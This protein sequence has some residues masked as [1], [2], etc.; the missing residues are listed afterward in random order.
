R[1]FLG[2]DPFV[3]MANRQLAVLRG[4]SWPWL[5]GDTGLYHSIPHHASHLGP[6]ADLDRF[7]SC[8]RSLASP[9][10]L[11]RQ[12]GRTPTDES[13]NGVVDFRDARLGSW[14]SRRSAEKL[15][16]SPMFANPSTDS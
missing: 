16:R 1:L 12:L 13:D 8:T 9:G 15:D 2:T 11:R 6:P 4:D 3:T 10:D 7:V 5:R 14:A